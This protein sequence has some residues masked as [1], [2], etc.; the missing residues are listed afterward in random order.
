[1]TRRYPHVLLACVFLLPGCIPYATATTAQP[2]APGEVVPTAIMYGIPG[3]IES[4]RA[5]HG[6]QTDLP[7]VGP[8]AEVRFGIDDRSDIGVRLPSMS[9]I[10][11]NYKRR[12]TASDDRSDA[13]VAIMGG[14][15]FVN[16]F[17]HAW[18]ELT[19]LASGRQT[20]FT[21][22]GGL[23]VSQVA[24]IARGAVHDSPTAG[25]FMGLRIGREDL[26][27]SPEVGFYHDRSALELRS[28]DY[29]FVLSV[30]LHGQE[31]IDA[32]GTALSLGGR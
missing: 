23:R 13:A 1:M 10:V 3:G 12:L 15:G 8:D 4:L 2:V 5:D 14:A 32:L 11:V 19:L 16:G 29:I 25:G 28:S 9:G 6:E 30:D 18:F 26:G 20:R 31:L 7:L 17:N 21:P 24:P 22:Y 27:V